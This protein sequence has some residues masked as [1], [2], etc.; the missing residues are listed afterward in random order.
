[1]GGKSGGKKGGGGGRAYEYHM[2]LWLGLCAFGHGIELLEVKI[3][4]RSVWKGA[5]RH[6][7]RIGVRLPK[8]FGGPEREGGVGGIL[9]WLP[10]G[11]HQ[12]LPTGLSRRLGR[13][14]Y[15]CPAA[16]GIAS[17]FLTGFG[18][19]G[20]Y[21]NEGWDDW[22]PRPIKT[23][24]DGDASGIVGTLNG[25][26]RPGFLL[27]ANN[28]YLRPITARLRRPSIGLDPAKAMLPVDP[29]KPDGP[30]GSN[31][32]H[33]VYECLTDQAWG[34]GVA[35]GGIDRA[36]Y[37]A[38]ADLFYNEGFALAGK[39]TRQGPVEDFIN[40]VLDHVNATQ[41]LH[42]RTGKL[43]LKPLRDDYDIAS[44]RHVHPGNARLSNF[45]RKTWG[46]TANEITVTWTNPENEKEET[47][48]AQDLANVAA[49]GSVVSSGR[50]Y[51]MVRSARMAGI[52]AQREVAAA[53][54]PLVTC[55]I[56]INRTG[57]DL[58]PGEVVVLTWP[59]HNVEQIACRVSNVDYGSASSG[60]IKASLLEDIFGVPLSDYISRQDPLDAG[61]GGADPVPPPFVKT[62]TAPAIMTSNALGLSDP[63]ELTY[64]DAVV[65]LLP[66]PIP[67]G[68]EC[69]LMA[70]EVGPSGTATDTLI[71]WLDFPG[72][73]RLTAPLVQEAE[74]LVAALTDTGGDLPEVDDFILI[75]DG[76]ETETE[77]AVV[78]AS[79]E[80]GWTLRRGLL[81]T[82]PREWAAGTRI[83]VVRNGAIHFD[84]ITRGASDEIDYR[85]LPRTSRGVLDVDSAPVTQV[86]VTERAHLPLRPANVWVEGVAFGMLDATGLTGVTVSWSNR[87]RTTDTTVPLAWTAAT[88]TP[89]DGQTT[90]I[91]LID[92]SDDSII[93]TIDD[94]PGTSHWIEKHEFA[95]TEFVRVRVTSKRDGMESLQGHEI[96]IQWDIEPGLALSGDQAGGVLSLS[97]DQA[98]GALVLSGDQ[99]E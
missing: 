17:L 99:A 69:E 75:G 89:E 79:D 10:G 28:P 32:A 48:A 50:N 29:D 56:E 66:A 52:L 53:G 40:E 88:V 65:G 16:R 5:Y 41:F 19:I 12:V 85:I 73:G 92:D 70:P 87:N 4:E 27:G 21:V 37:E 61:E 71:G 3:G 15:D 2:S 8:L 33:I 68:I 36:S 94:L 83:W 60:V 20:S 45:Q 43:T 44:L 47:V 7:V 72:V 90:T 6:A 82:V 11:P 78:T 34:A 76:D 96:R 77:I 26:T 84:P 91:T 74:S 35:P 42:P 98:P 59:E 14:R 62:L 54:Q 46:E 63:G 97:G 49:Q 51:H 22:V 1:M 86:T 23:K 95:R 24:A 58:V 55:D 25:S 13:S 9:H 38:A 30:M 81:D 93:A 18:S 67:D 64:P 39:W 31:P 80:T 57:W